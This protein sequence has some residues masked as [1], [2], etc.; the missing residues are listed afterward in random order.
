M[1]HNINGIVFSTRQQ[2]LEDFLRKRDVDIALLHEVAT[3]NNINFRGYQTVI[4]I[5]TP[6]RGTAIL[7]KVDP[8]I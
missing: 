5:G 4:N 8:H 7:S 3:E 1:T 2:M 6:A